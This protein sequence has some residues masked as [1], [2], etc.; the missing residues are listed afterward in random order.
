[1]KYLFICSIAFLISCKSPS[2]MTSIE[3]DKATER[4]EILEKE[5]NS[6]SEIQ[7]AE[8]DLFNV[9]GFSKGRIFVAGGSSFRYDYV[10][11]IDTSELHKW[12]DDMIITAGDEYSVKR[13]EELVSIRKENWN[14]NSKPTY[15][16]SGDMGNMMVYKEEGIIFKSIYVE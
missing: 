2:E 8:Y 5:I 16:K 13:F 9:N 3:V 1:M 11:K 15:Y 4:V 10:I 7:D 14:V 6:F 12:T